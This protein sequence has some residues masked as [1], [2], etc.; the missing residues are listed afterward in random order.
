MAAVLAVDDDF[1]AAKRGVARVREA[2]ALSRGVRRR[3]V[4]ATAARRRRLRRRRQAAHAADAGR[5]RELGRV[6]RSVRVAVRGR[7]RRDETRASSRHGRGRLLLSRAQSQSPGHV[8]GLA[9]RQQGPQALRR[10]RR[11]SRWEAR[12]RRNQAGTRHAGSGVEQRQSALRRPLRRRPAPAARRPRRPRL[13]RPRLEALR[14]RRRGRPRSE[15]RLRRPYARARHGPTPPDPRP[16]RRRRPPHPP[17]LAL[18]LRTRRLAPPLGGQRLEG[19]QSSAAAAA[20]PHLS[21]RP[22]PQL[23]WPRR[24]SARGQRQPT[25]LARVRRGCSRA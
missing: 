12:R 5:Q 16:A 13:R 14:S 22:G 11:H 9:P 7:R 1:D 24:R 2:E 10:P 3:L 20:A 25:R 21:R 23:R 17:R 19:T 8:P 18:R 15:R 6:P 4:L